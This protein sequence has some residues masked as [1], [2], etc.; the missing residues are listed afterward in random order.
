MKYS[1]PHLLCF[2]FLSLHILSSLEPCT[3]WLTYAIS[4]TGAHDGE[5]AGN[6]Q[7][8]KLCLQYSSCLKLGLLCITE[9]FI[10]SLAES[11]M[12]E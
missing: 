12:R 1:Y 9:Y 2:L 10:N 7:L 8:H 3:W 4:Q 6:M 5:A 11:E